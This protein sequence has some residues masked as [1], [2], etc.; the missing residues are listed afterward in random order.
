MAEEKKPT[1]SKKK[2][3]LDEGE[4][5][6]RR[7]FNVVGWGT[8]AAGMGLASAGTGLFF[9][10]RVLYEP[11]MAFPMRKPEEYTPNSVT[12]DDTNGVYLVR[13]NNRFYAIIS[14]CTHLGCTPR[15]FGDEMLEGAQAKDFW[16][17]KDLGQVKGVFK[18]PCHGSKYYGLAENGGMR[19]GVNFYGPAPRPMDR[20]FI[21]LS[22]DG[23]IWIDKS[24]KYVYDLARGLDQFGQGGSPADGGAF[25]DV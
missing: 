21:K 20:A 17:Q 24:K 6:R 9:Y 3:V 23:R 12:V 2:E 8:F 7:F 14:I 18:C 1:S 25:I 13:E 15:F 11:P 10:P 16:T 19:A 4:L 22:P 5:S